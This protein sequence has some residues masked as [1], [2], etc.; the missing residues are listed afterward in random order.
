MHIEIRKLMRA[1]SGKGYT[2]QMRMIQKGS[3]CWAGEMSL[4]FLVSAVGDGRNPSLFPTSPLSLWPSILLR[5][6]T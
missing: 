3:F 5:R 4:T 2:T 6:E 1:R